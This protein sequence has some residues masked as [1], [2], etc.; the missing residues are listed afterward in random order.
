MSRATSDDVRMDPGSPTISAGSV[1]TPDPQAR[2]DS[3][4]AVES[5]RE[6]TPHYN[7]DD[8]LSSRSR[9]DYRGQAVEAQT[10]AARGH[11]RANNA[12]TAILEEYQRQSTRTRLQEVHFSMHEESLHASQVRGKQWQ[13]VTVEVSV[14]LY[15]RDLQFYRRKDV[16]NQERGDYF[17]YMTSEAKR[18]TEVRISQLNATDKEKFNKAKDTELDQWISHAVV[19]VCQ[20]SGVPLQRIM[21]MRWVLTWKTSDD[22]KDRKAK[23]R[24]VVRGF[25]D[26]DLITV[27]AE[28]PTLS[29]PARH[30]ILQMAASHQWTAEV[31]DVKTAFLQGDKTETQRDVYLEPVPEIRQKLRMKPE[32][33]LKLEG[34]A[35]GLRTA[36]RTWY[37]RVKKDLVALGWRMHQ[38]DQYTFMYYNKRGEIIGLIGVYVDD[39]LI[40]GSK[41][42]PEWQRVK[43]QVIDLY[44]WGK[45]DKSKFSLC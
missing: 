32:Q 10:S 12:N 4:I 42:N 9:S 29:K 13:D 40:A 5:S 41:K 18:H 35:Y 1:P 38:L 37:Q 8:D 36:P 27:R 11:G 22:Q 30:M 17:S 34:S 3:P 2:P 39:F 43:Q 7:P 45:W 28:A 33:L 25:E 16:S 6:G 31:G 20:R 26:P 21:S 24:L 14:P 15:D 23:A 44:S 19:R